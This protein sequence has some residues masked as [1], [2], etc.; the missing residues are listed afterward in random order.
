MGQR[1]LHMHFLY[2][3]VILYFEPLGALVGAVLLHVKPTIFLGAM[4]RGAQYA[5]DNQIIYHQLA[6]AYVLFAFN[7]AVLL[8]T[9]N[10]VRVWRY[11]LA[12]ILACDALHLYGS[13]AA[14][15]STVFWNPH[16]W[17]WED[18]FN[19]GTLWAQSAVRV[20]FL[21]GIGLKLDAV[22]KRE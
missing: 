8:R 18:W 4:D 3:A 19:L 1:I 10:D 6:A 11:A 5:P 2:R 12:G 16:Y 13:W 14:L 21:A 17:R 22:S 7:E 15:G 9:T 20:A